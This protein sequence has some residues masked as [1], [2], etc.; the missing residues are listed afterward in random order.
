MLK[1]YLRRPIH[2]VSAD[3]NEN[4]LNKVAAFYECIDFLRDPT[5]FDHEGINSISTLMWRLIRSGEVSLT[6]DQGDM[7]LLTFA[8]IEKGIEQTPMVVIPRNFLKQVNTNPIFQLGDFVYIASQCRDYYSGRSL[9]H[10]AVEADIRAR[11]Y[12][13]EAFNMFEKMASEEG[14][15]LNFNLSQL[16][17]LKHLPKEPLKNLPPGINYRTPIYRKPPKNILNN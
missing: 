4:A 10:N 12:A 6:L 2:H 13:A 3:S 16:E 5:R 14:V 15:E 11:A 9:L 7:T 1:E 8:V 17:Y